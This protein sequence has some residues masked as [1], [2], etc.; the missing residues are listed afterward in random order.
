MTQT[1]QAGQPQTPANPQNM[2]SSA[3]PGGV[4]Q[5]QPT[6]PE[7]AT[8][9]PSDP[10]AQVPEQ[11]TPPVRTPVHASLRNEALKR[12]AEK[13]KEELAQEQRDHTAATG[14][15]PRAYAYDDK[16]EGVQ[17]ILTDEKG[18]PLVQG[19]PQPDP[20]QQQY[21][22][23]VNQYQQSQQ[24]QQPPQAQQAPQAPLA[25]PMS[26]YPTPPQVDMASQMNM[27]PAMTA[28]VAAES[29]LVETI[30]GEPMLKLKV[31]GQIQYTPLRDA[32]Q[33]IQKAAGAEARF[34]EVNQRQQELDR[35]EA[36]LNAR[37]SQASGQDAKP[38]G[39]TQ[40]SSDVGQ[41]RDNL[42]DDVV[43][44]VNEMIDGDADGAVKRL[45]P[46]FQ[47][48]HGTQGQE[49]IAEIAAAKAREELARTEKER[50]VLDRQQAV[51]RGRA[52][53]NNQYPDLVANPALFAVADS[54]TER[55]TNDFPHLT[56]EQAMLEAGRQT[57]EWVNTVRGQQSAQ[58]IPFPNPAS[59]DRNQRKQN[60]VPMVQAAAGAH[61]ALGGQEQI[62][63]YDQYQRENYSRIMDETRRSRGQDPA[64]AYNRRMGRQV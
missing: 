38:G 54:F 19:Q 3:V 23:L 42:R 28:P 29:P 25:N 50:E 14:K 35:R 48:S 41:G 55:L 11:E 56:P 24:V 58:V 57:R 47:A 8:G 13:R 17:M 27:A 9:Q 61:Q 60:L 1:P 10:A 16:G 43:R 36:E 45:L 26:Y 64:F 63:D 46:L 33:Q 34:A 40:P 22:Q 59:T 32:H 20:H 2:G 39:E 15:P 44:A 5:G 4:P 49:R 31:N 21:Q 7:N 62:L 18:Q 12:I 52:A 30:N 53:F 51:Y 37:L 6:R